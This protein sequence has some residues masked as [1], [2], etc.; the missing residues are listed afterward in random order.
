MFAPAAKLACGDAGAQ[1]KALMVP[2]ET[3]G[4][5]LALVAAF[6]PMLVHVAVKPLIT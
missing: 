5:Q 3:V 2:A 1:L 6:A 4:T